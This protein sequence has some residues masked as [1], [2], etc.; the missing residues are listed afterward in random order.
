MLKQSNNK[1]AIQKEYGFRYSALIELPYFDPIRHTVIDPM[2]NLFLGT[3]KH[4]LD[5][6]MKR[7]ILTKSDIEIIE[8]QMSHL[9]APHSVGRLPLKIGTGFSGFTAD[10]WRNWRVGFS[11]IVLRGVLPT[12]HLRYWLLF[13]K[14]CSLICTR[15]LL[16]EN[17]TLADQYFQMFCR[18][19]LD[20]NGPTACT[21]NMHLHL[22][23][24]E[25]LFDYGPPYAF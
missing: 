18:Q 12:E 19:F 5:L 6:W 9:Y 14:A 3:A 25:C 10:Q 7:E 16:K 8:N 22:H 24:K 13:V 1:K 4:C 20:V 21:P 2:H 23:L 17:V 15:C 11:A